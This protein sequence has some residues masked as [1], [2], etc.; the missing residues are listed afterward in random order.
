VRTRQWSDP[1]Q[2]NWARP[3]FT[4]LSNVSFIQTS[5]VES[6][7]KRVHTKRLGIIITVVSRDQVYLTAAV[8]A[9]GRQSQS[10]AVANGFTPSDT[11]KSR[12]NWLWNVQNLKN[13]RDQLSRS[14]RLFTYSFLVWLS[15]DTSHMTHLNSTKQFS[16]VAT[17]GVNTST[18]R[19]N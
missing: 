18:I 2:L 15:Y 3:V 12:L 1:S 9:C 8:I 16:W 4:I 6:D 7:R 11:S 14:I 10:V 5:W 13:W 19:L 17:F